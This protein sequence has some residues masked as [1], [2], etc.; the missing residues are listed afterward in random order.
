MGRTYN[1]RAVTSAS[2][3]P[4]RRSTRDSGARHVWVALLTLPLVL[5]LPTVA[6]AQE[7]E[8]AAPASIRLLS[9]TPA[10][11]PK[12]PMQLTVAITNSGERPLEDLVVALWIYNPARSRSAYQ[13]GL[14]DEPPTEPLVVDPFPQRSSLGPGETRE[15]SITHKLP[16]LEARGENALYPVKVQVESNGVAVG[17]LRTSIVFIQER[18]LVPLNVSLTF[19]LDAPI[20]FRP[21]GVL[22]EPTI[23]QQLAPGGR[24]ETIVGALERRPVRATLVVSPLL[25]EALEQ[26]QDGYRIIDASG[27]RTVPD[28]DPEALRA[29]E[30]LERL[31]ALSLNTAI[32]TLA[33][34]YAS[35][36]IPALV[37]SGLTDDL[38]QQIA[39]GRKVLE[40]V[41]GAPIE[42][43]ILY[44]PGSSITT[45]SL[46]L[47]PEDIESLI[48]GAD[49]LRPLPDLNL[50][51]PATALVGGSHSAV[52]P[53]AGAAAYLE[54]GDDPRLQAQHAIGEL[55]AIYFEEPSILRGAALLIDEETHP[56]PLFLEP[57]LGAL[58][59][60]SPRGEWLRP[61]KASQLLAAVPPEERRR[62]RRADLPSLSASLVGGV[63]AGHTAIEQFESITNGDLALP[64]R[65]RSL[66]LVAESR[67]YVG[68]DSSARRFV[69][70]VRDRVAREFQKIEP[71]AGSSVT[72]TSRG[73]VIPVTMRKQTDYE[74]RVRITLRSPRLDFLEGGSREVLLS[75]EAEALN[76]RVRAQTTGRFPVRILVDTPSGQRIVESNIVIRSTAYN[77]VALLVTIGAALF[78]AGWWGRRFLRRV[79]S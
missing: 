64:S 63:E 66:L 72:L 39:H 79:R 12:R 51:P 43:A 47:L 44:P 38:E 70:A 5:A 61:T 1:G 26:M 14:E 8:L 20:R 57:F 50:S 53:D 13:A 29:G 24:L 55:S 60:L 49:M 16:E 59:D 6:G 22:L 62:I 76:F 68:R 46:D 42:G 77:R 40:E 19:V 54:P 31:R 48:L 35:P 52:V 45:D 65:L 37:R 32:E 58:T 17:A 33:L 3:R 27:E 28:R 36:S 78:L 10:A 7:E 56:S 73:G 25:V 11:T 18:P 30:M 21:D 74:V 15:F 9:Q 69:D 34:P 41:L 2:R 23:E 4:S 67:N 75:S 71:P